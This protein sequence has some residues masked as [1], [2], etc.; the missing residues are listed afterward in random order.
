MF[1]ITVGSGNSGCGAVHDY[2]RSRDDFSTPFF[3]QEFRL[4][5]DPDGIDNLYQNFYE[6]FTIN[7]AASA[8]ERFKIYSSQ[9]I[10]SKVYIDGKRKN[11]FNDEAESLIHNFV[12]NISNL[13]YYAMPKYKYLSLNIFEKLL[14]YFK[15]QLLNE[16]IN[17]IKLHKLIL[18]VEEKKFVN[19]TK[20]LIFSLCQNNIKLKKNII[21][22]QSASYW[23]PDR[24]FRYFNNLKIIIINRDPRSI[25]YSMSSRNSKA[26]PSESVKTFCNWYKYIR[27]KQ[28]K[29]KNKNIYCIQYEK[30]VNNF[31]IESKKLN[32]FLNIK[33]LNTTNFDLNY[34]KKNVYKAK[35]Q[36]KKSDQ[37][38]IK[39]NL[40]NFLYW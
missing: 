36:L 12:I 1:V 18:P 29:I 16:K 40:K 26:Y 13:K 14:F 2:L 4:I 31:K 27:G 17:K 35:F 39:K 34:S 8:F 5:N 9:I 22:D 25:Y 37:L 10:K 21:L 24:Y 28:F 23:R 15:Y 30:F 7:N 3:G 38:Y 6:N 20:K 32:R 33:E 11:L 19:E